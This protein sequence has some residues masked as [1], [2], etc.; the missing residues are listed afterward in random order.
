[1]RLDGIELSERTV[2]VEREQ[3]VRRHAIGDQRHDQ[4]G[5]GAAGVRERTRSGKRLH[6][7]EI[8]PGLGLAVFEGL[9]IESEHLSAREVEHAMA[10]AG[11]RDAL[12]SDIRHRRAIAQVFHQMR[13]LRKLVILG[14]DDVPFDIAGCLHRRSLGHHV[15]I[16]GGDRHDFDARGLGEGVEEVLPQRS[17]EDAACCADHERAFQLAACGLRRRLGHWECAGGKCSNTAEK[18]LATIDPHGST[19]HFRTPDRERRPSL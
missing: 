10:A 4:I 6:I 8:G 12:R 15:A 13:Q 5:P 3:L 18:H 17:L 16:G 9:R 11:T 14:R 19:S 2:E 7:P 1:M